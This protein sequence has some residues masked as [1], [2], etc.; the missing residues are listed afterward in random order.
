MV[1]K[2]SAS[3]YNF[4]SSLSNILSLFGQFHRSSPRWSAEMS[5]TPFIRLGGSL[6]FESL[7][8]I[9]ILSV[10]DVNSPS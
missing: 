6:G 7:M 9:T 8:E 3:T 1:L 10:V 4:V 2:P 5:P